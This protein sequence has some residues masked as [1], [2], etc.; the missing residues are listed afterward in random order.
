MRITPARVVHLNA[1]S[2][3][4]VVCLD[5]G[6]GQACLL[7]ETYQKNLDVYCGAWRTSRGGRFLSIGGT[8]LRARVRASLLLFQNSP[9][10]GKSLHADAKQAADCNSVR[11]LLHSHWH[12]GRRAFTDWVTCREA[13]V[14][15]LLSRRTA[16]QWLAAA[17]APRAWMH[18]DGLPAWN[19]RVAALAGQRRN[20]FGSCGGQCRRQRDR[21]L[22]HF[23]FGR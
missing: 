6:H 12:R 7:C 4:G 3:R 17:I 22:G 18:F 5:D 10:K 21:W 9:I 11:A 15:P 16:R 23:K 13:R 1:E 19:G 8:G 14:V 2:V 20:P